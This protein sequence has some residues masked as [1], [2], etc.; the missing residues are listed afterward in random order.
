[1]LKLLQT[2]R[3]AWALL[4][5]PSGGCVLKRERCMAGQIEALAAA[6]GRLCV[7]TWHSAQ[8]N[9]TWTQPPSG[10]CVLKPRPV[11]R[12]VCRPAAAAFGRLCVETPSAGLMLPSGH[13]AAFGRLCVE[14]PP[15]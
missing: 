14:T 12:P 7:E 3:P 1:M 10:G 8:S 11:C 4:Q 2:L 6:F 5:P 9:T 13:A 15:C